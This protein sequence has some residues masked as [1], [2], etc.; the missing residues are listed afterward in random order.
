MS[1]FLS[2]L[3]E[4]LNITNTTSLKVMSYQQ[5]YLV[6]VS[7]SPFPFSYYSVLRLRLCMTMREFHLSFFFFHFSICRDC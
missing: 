5:R 4:D 6:I 7:S 1:W 2:L 3:M